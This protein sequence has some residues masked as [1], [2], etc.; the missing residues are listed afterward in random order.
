MY[1]YL[2]QLYKLLQRRSLLRRWNGW[3][4]SSFFI[5]EDE[6]IIRIITAILCELRYLKD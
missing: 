4:I 6:Y 1:K 5:A 3:Y 2:L